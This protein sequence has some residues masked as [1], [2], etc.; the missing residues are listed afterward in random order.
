[1]TQKFVEF[2]TPDEDDQTQDE[3]ETDEPKENTIEETK[4]NGDGNKY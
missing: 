1:M 3:S 2:Y 4:D